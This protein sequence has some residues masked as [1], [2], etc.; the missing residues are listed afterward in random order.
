M[1]P[2]LALVVA[3]SAPTIPTIQFPTG[4]LAPPR[5]EAHCTALALFLQRT[6]PARCL[7]L[8]MTGRR[9]SVAGRANAFRSPHYTRRAVG[10]RTSGCG[11]Q[12]R[13]IAGGAERSEAR[14]G[15]EEGRG[16]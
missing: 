11:K 12:Y 4:A 14:R 15:G 7:P 6:M 16:R 13:T 9:S 10:R 8:R 5:F 2:V 3:P 1:S